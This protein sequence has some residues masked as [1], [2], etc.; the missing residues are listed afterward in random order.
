MQS[1]LELVKDTLAGREQ[2]LVMMINR[3]RIFTGQ[4]FGFDPNGS[5]QEKEQAIAAWEQWVEES[6]RIQLTPD[7]PLIPV[8]R[9][10]NPETP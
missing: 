5:D 1:D 8:P 6:G 4:N 10:R 9:A 2:S 7:A 3:L